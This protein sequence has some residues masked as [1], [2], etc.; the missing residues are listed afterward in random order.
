MGKK[1]I[2]WAGKYWSFVI[3]AL[4]LCCVIVFLAGH[5]ERILIESNDNA[6]SN[7]AYYKAYRDALLN[8]E[9]DDNYTSPILG[10]DESTRRLFDKGTLS[11]IR[12]VYTIFPTFAAYIVCYFLRIILG[13]VGWLLLSRICFDKARYLRMQN[14]TAMLGFVYG[15]L[16]VWPMSFCTSFLPFMLAAGVFAYKK[17][18]AWAGLTAALYP[19][20]GNSLALY[21]VFVLGYL[22]LFLIIDT[23]WKKRLNKGLIS[24][25]LALLIIYFV[26]ENS[27]IQYVSSGSSIRTGFTSQEIPAF[28]LKALIRS[29][30]EILRSGHYHSGT[31][32]RFF[33]FPLCLAYFVLHNVL[34]II[35]RRKLKVFLTDPFNICFCWFILNGVIYSCTSDA[36]IMNCV[37][38]IVP[39]LRGISLTR[40]LW[41]NPLALYLSVFF[42]IDDIVSSEIRIIPQLALLILLLSVIAVNEPSLKVSMYNDT[43]RNLSEALFP[44]GQTFFKT[45]K[46]IYSEELFAQIKE[47]I[48]YTGEW[49]AAYGLQ[50][51]VLTYNGIRTLDGYDSGYSAEYK[52]QF[53][54]LIRPYLETGKNY[55]DYYNNGGIRAYLFSDD[56]GF[57][58]EN[59][60]KK[61]SA[62]L[63][64]DGDVFREMGGVYVF[65]VVEITNSDE[66][67]LTLL[68]TWT[69]PESLYHMHV[70]KA[71]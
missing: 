42:I 23:L 57:E 28:D 56:I 3:I 17:N 65:S 63:Y 70:Y 18:K 54:K 37:Y 24:A 38:R 13:V 44:S 58:P 52:E 19:F 32:Q 26:K 64:M 34:M 35:K 60:T 49:S 15:L 9:I 69:H 43:Q 4:F 29:T 2:S 8:G 53:A 55:V 41:F 46:Q 47:E 1:L 39:M 16:P 27:M 31:N 11:P 50:P 22:L 40:A 59:L 12:A 61:E 6:D 48:G 68:G 67:G 30:W 21:G 20:L 7:I 5:G 14:F 10:G 71:D 33:A 62:P 25:F 51:S 66:L 36:A 45:W